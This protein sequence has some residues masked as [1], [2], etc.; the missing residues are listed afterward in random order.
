MS[1][2]KKIKGRK[3][4]REREF[5]KTEER[6]LDLKSISYVPSSKIYTIVSILI[7]CGFVGSPKLPP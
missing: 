3:E 7:D 6:Y 5:L 1:K 2:I 4:G